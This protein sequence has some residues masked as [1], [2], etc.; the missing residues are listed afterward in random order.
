MWHIIF[1]EG[2]WIPPPFALRIGVGDFSKATTYDLLVRAGGEGYIVFCFPSVYVFVGESTTKWLHGLMPHVS[3]TKLNY[4]LME[5]RM[6][7]KHPRTPPLSSSPT[8]LSLYMHIVNVQVCQLSC[9][10]TDHMRPSRIVKKVILF[11]R[12]LYRSRNSCSRVGSM[13]EYKAI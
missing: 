4:M 11:S 13:H 2:T 6:L 8:P 1:D 10:Y 12:L 5:L 9:K 7:L 3:P